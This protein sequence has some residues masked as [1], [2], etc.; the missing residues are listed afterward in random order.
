M[1]ITNT[2]ANEIADHIAA[3]YRVVAIGNG[4]DTTSLQSTGL[5]SFVRMK[6]GIIPNVA[7]SSLIYN[8][9]F[10]GAEIPSSGVSELGIFKTGTGE[11]SGT[12]PPNGILLS[13]VTFTNTGVVGSSD[14]VS[15]QVR[16]EVGNE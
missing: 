16:L 10:T 2:G 5:N 7:G 4:G 11:S 1:T 13:R 8:V 15:F 12:T 14:T 3:T 9:S 6:T